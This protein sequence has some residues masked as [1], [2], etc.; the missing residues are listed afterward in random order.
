MNCSCRMLLRGGM[1]V[2]FALG[3]LTPPGGMLSAEPGA[4]P[5]FAAVPRPDPSKFK[6]LVAFGLYTEMLKLD[7]ALEGWK[8]NGRHAPEFTWVNCPPNAVEAFP[9]SNDKLFA[10]NTVVLSD[11]N[12]KAIGQRGFDMLCDY[13]EQGGRLLVTGGPYALGNGEFEGS[14]FLQVLPVTLRGPFDLK[15]AGQGKSWA[16]RPA[17]RDSALLAGVSFV[18]NPQVFWQH[19]VTPKSGA[20]VVLQAGDQPALVVGRY[21]QGKVAVLTLSPTGEGAAGQTPWWDWDGRAPLMKSL[22]SWLNDKQEPK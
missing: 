16:L 19:F 18:Q 8:H 2:A 4:K 10:Y 13:V 14:R 3:L 11:V 9:D 15:W 12:Y 1:V 5:N 21:G 17:A 6:C 7:D 20:Q 22:F